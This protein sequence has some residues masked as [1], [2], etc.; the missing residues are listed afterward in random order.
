MDAR[1]THARRRQHKGGMS[2]RILPIQ[3]GG[4]GP[5]VQLDNG[6]AHRQRQSEPFEMTPVAGALDV[7]AGSLS[8]YLLRGLYAALILSAATSSPAGTNPKEEVCG[9]DP[10]QPR[11]EPATG[12]FSATPSRDGAARQL[13]SPRHHGLAG[14]PLGSRPNWV[15]Y[16]CFLP[17]SK[18]QIAR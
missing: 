17:C 1:P 7:A 10:D 2:I 4:V 6:Q 5:S 11:R 12:A 18:R 16:L 9:P 13:T 14:P 8:H 15:P 3:F